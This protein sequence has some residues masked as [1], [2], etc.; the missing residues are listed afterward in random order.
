MCDIVKPKNFDI[1]L[2]EFSEMKTNQYGGKVVYLKYN[3]GKFRLQTPKM[4]MPYGMNDFE[5]KDDGSEEVKGHKYTLDMSFKGI[6]RE[7]DQSVS[8]DVRKEAKRLSEFHSVLT[9]IDTKVKEQ[10][11]ANSIAWLK[12][13]KAS[14]EMI[15]QQYKSVLNVSMDKE[16][17][18]PDGKWPDT[19]KTKIQYYDGVFKTEVYNEKREPVDIQEW[20]GKG[21][22]V[23]SLIECSGIWFAGGKFGIGFKVIQTQV[24]YK[25]QESYGYCAIT[26]SD[27]DDDSDSDDSDSDSDDSG[28]DDSGDS[29]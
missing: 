6:D 24:L 11:K 15:T 29:K 19:A 20:L 12:C 3:G 2:L 26:L 9:S 23:A 4:Y 16:T 21:S 14:D 25:P 13:K 28:N 18:E 27:S 1:T 17:L 10:A 22:Q 7:N 8:S 5:I